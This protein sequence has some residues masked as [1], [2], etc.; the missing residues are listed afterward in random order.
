MLLWLVKQGGG[1]HAEL[2]KQ[3]A[4]RFDRIADLEHAGNHEEMDSVRDNA[5][6]VIPDATMR[7]LWR[8]LLSGCVKLVERDSDLY[9]WQI[10]FARDGLTTTLRLELCEMLTPCVLLNE[11][12]QWPFNEDEEDEGTE[13]MRQLVDWSIVLSVSH[14]HASLLGLG[15]NER[16]RAALLVLL[17]DFTRL[18]RDVLDLMRELDGVDEKSDLSYSS[19][20]S[21][22]EHPQNQNFRDWTA[23]INLNRDAW[24]ATSA[25]SPRCVSRELVFNRRYPVAPLYSGS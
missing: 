16:W 4:Y 18:L 1:L 2:S 11:P 5:P 6:A 10:R 15:D 20:P 22:S 14:V 13:Y 7:K 3:I 12:I 24:L 8:L 19:Q 9:E 25:E 17:P 23:L 21:I